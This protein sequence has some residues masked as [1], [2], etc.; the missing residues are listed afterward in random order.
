MLSTLQFL[1][2]N[3]IVPLNETK[4]CHLFVSYFL[5]CRM[6]TSFSTRLPCRRCSI[7]A[8]R[9]P[10]LVCLSQ[11]NSWAWADSDS[12]RVQTSNINATEL[13][14]SRAQVCAKSISYT[15]VKDLFIIPPVRRAFQHCTLVPTHSLDG[16]IY[17]CHYIPFQFS[18]KIPL[19]HYA[20]CSLK[21]QLLSLIPQIRPRPRLDVTACTCH[22]RLTIRENRPV[23]EPDL[24]CRQDWN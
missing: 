1:H 18:W 14:P 11:N 16:Q 21:Q 7:L 19:F 2:E 4:G 6:K 23:Y 22:G 8:I 3:I 20:N 24:L 15:V 17:I 12:C 5:V 13:A 9:R 10:C